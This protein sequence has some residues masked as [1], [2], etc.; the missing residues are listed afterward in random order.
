MSP[1][2]G[3]TEPVAPGDQDPIEFQPASLP[4][5]KVA[6]SSRK[7]KPCCQHFTAI[8]LSATLFGY[9]KAWGFI[10][11]FPHIQCQPFLL[12]RSPGLQKH[13]W[14]QNKNY[15]GPRRK[16]WA[17]PIGK[18][19]VQEFLLLG[20][21]EGVPSSFSPAPSHSPIPYILRGNFHAFS[22][23]LWLFILPA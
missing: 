14:H 18:L 17:I 5:D 11:N 1:R 9:L 21:G 10:P 15:K 20:Q 8:T 3:V 2:P 13:P 16:K 19:F 23:L 22:C 12:L 6:Y 4:R 7:N